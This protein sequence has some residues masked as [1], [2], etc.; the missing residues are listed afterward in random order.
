MANAIF[1]PP[2]SVRAGSLWC[3]SLLAL[4]AVVTAAPANH[5]ALDGSFADQTRLAFAPVHAMLK[6][7]EAFLPVRIYIIGNGRSTQGDGF[8]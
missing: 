7:K 4:G 3:F 5:D 6:L 1:T 8:S 2:Q